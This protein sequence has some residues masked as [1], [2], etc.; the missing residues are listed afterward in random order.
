[1]MRPSG[2][3]PPAGL[4]AAQGLA[5]LRAYLVFLADEIVGHAAWG[6]RRMAWAYGVGRMAWSYGVGHGAYGVRHPKG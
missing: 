5:A 4:S 2:G 1:M 3:Q 6:V